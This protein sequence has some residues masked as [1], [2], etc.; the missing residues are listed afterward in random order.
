MPMQKHFDYDSD[1]K[2]RVSI[3]NRSVDFAHDGYT[4]RTSLV[5]LDPISTDTGYYSCQYQANNT[6]NYQGSDRTYI[7]V[8]GILD[9][10][11]I[12]EM[13]LYLKTKQFSPTKPKFWLLL[14]EK[15]WLYILRISFNAHGMNDNVQ[16]IG[17]Y[18][19]DKNLI[20]HPPGVDFFHIA[21]SQF[22][23]GIIP[24]KPSHPSVSLVLHNDYDQ[25]S[26]TRTWLLPVIQC[27]KKSI[28]ICNYFKSNYYLQKPECSWGPLNQVNNIIFLIGKKIYNS[29]TIITKNKYYDYNKIV[30]LISI[31]MLFYFILRFIHQLIPDGRMIQEKVSLSWKYR[32]KP[33]GYTPVQLT[34]LFSANWSSSWMS[35]VI[36]DNLLIIVD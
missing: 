35:S 29:K 23:R 6:A 24:C 31:M 1:L 8:R 5:V 30:I 12:S 14:I 2:K 25:V 33:V 4:Y 27:K 20:V 34:D 16:Y 3:R 9:L 19:D 18:L 7:Y 13:F 15:K 11:I 22:S 36:I 21:A 10:L 26:Y 17:R 32:W 28:V